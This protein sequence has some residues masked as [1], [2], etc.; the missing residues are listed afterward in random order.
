MKERTIFENMMIQAVGFE[1]IKNFPG[2]TCI[3]VGCA[4]GRF[5]VPLGYATFPYGKIIAFDP[6]ISTDVLRAQY[7]LKVSGVDIRLFNFALSD[8][9]RME[10]FRVY[11]DRIDTY[12]KE[13]KSHMFEQNY[14]R[15]QEVEVRTLDSMNIKSKVSFIKIDAEGCD[16]DIINGGIELI[17]TNQPV[18]IVEK[19]PEKYTEQFISELNEICKKIGYTAR[20][21]VNTDYIE[22]S[23]HKNLMLI[24]AYNSHIN[25]IILNLYSQLN[26]A[27]TDF[28]SKKIDGISEWLRLR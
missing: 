7:L 10:T 23:K 16:L 4:S 6:L 13:D 2:S 5:L 21:M 8:T 18:I 14:V 15:S 28:F 19:Y 1:V 27:N 17:K 12:V 11:T 20:T 24:P 26:L 22:S 9:C 25:Q 3:D